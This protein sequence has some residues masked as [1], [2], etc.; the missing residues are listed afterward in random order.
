MEKIII[1]SNMGHEINLYESETNS[2][3]VIVII[4]GA[5]EGALRYGELAVKLSCV[6]NVITYNH[7][8]HETTK[9]VSFTKDEI[10]EKSKA[11]LSYTQK[12]YKEVTI[13]AHS[14]G[15]VVIRNL[16]VYLH[17]KTK[18][19]FSGAPVLTTKDK[20]LAIG[21]ILKLKRMNPNEVSLEMNYKVFDEKSSK[22]GLEEKA[23]LTSRK[24][25][26]EL[27]KSSKL[28][29]QPFTNGSL[30]ALL[31]LTNDAC[32]KSVYKK[33]A[34]FDLTLVSGATDVFTN[35]GMNYS[36]ITKYAS[37]ANVKVYPN[38][39]HEI[40]NDIDNHELIKDIKQIVEK[41]QNGKN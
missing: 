11:I 33:L 7:P 17:P 14:L 19:I 12:Q 6:C 26:V 1:D 28:N 3:K 25:M 20:L 10:L 29:N 38:S 30:I 31:E 24:L 16:L 2:D 8:G 15:T 22:I 41:E 36:F 32:E 21:G 34:K 37:D 27:F 4:H 9:N 5:S 39:Y 13:F 40:H 23:W 35:D 18:L